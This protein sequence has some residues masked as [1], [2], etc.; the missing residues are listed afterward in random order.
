MKIIDQEVADEIG[1]LKKVRAGE[2]LSV[3]EQ[4][5]LAKLGGDLSTAENIIEKEIDDVDKKIK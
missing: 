3:H 1:I 5:F 2:P 4:A